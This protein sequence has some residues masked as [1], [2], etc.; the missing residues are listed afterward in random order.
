[1]P[2][3]QTVVNS[4]Y[5]KIIHKKFKDCVILDDKVVFNITSLKF[6]KTTCSKKI[7][8][9]FRIGKYIVLNIDNTFIACHLRMT[10][11]LY[12]SSEPPENNKYLRCY[13]SFTDNTYLLY[14]DIR[15]FGGFFY[16]NNISFLKNKLGI[17]PFDLNFTKNW[18]SKNLQAKQRQIKS[19]LLDQKFITGLG[20]I[21][22]DEVL[23]K[24]KIHP[25]TKSNSI[26]KRKT[27]LLHNS[28]IKT[29]NDSIEHHGTTIIN[30]KFDNMKTGNYKNKLNVYG[31]LNQKCKKCSSIIKKI[32][33]ASRGTYI[34]ERCQC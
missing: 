16:F 24:S 8:D 30:F 28:I 3:V 2:E 25:R 33:V 34:C 10:G 17:D 14:E 32:R 22:I 11:Y 12:F 20:N 31:R 6:K 5:K 21:Y 9:I 18:L 7:N 26:N 4:L 29:L 23:W 1:M 27:K 19:L 15:K 13:F